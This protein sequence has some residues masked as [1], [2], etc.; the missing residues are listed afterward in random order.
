M[1]SSPTVVYPL[2]AVPEPYR[3]RL[4]TPDDVE[5]VAALYSDPEVARSLNFEVP[6]PPATI[7][8]K[9]ETDL[10]IMQ[11][12]ESFRW[13]LAREEDPAPLGYLTFFHWSPKDRRAEVG[14]MV[15]RS[16]WGQGVMTGVLPELIRF[17]FEHM[18][19][20]RIEA[21]VAVRNPASLKVVTRAGFQQEGVL[22]GY[23]ASATG[24]GF[25]DLVILALLEDAWRA[26]AAK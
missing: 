23:Q 20:H 22:R 8:R 25:N 10:E 6:L 14:Y 13:V 12:G 18:R 17:G 2:F 16:L 5:G 1:A 7:R 11:R 3:V 21:L 4:F 26:S 24:E 9:L 15:A 19:L